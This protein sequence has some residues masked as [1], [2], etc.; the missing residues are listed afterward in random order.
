[1]WWRALQV[2]SQPF[3]LILMRTQAADS[4]PAEAEAEDE[5]PKKA[6]PAAT[7]KRGVCF[8]LFVSSRVVQGGEMRI[9]TPCCQ[10]T[11]D[12]CL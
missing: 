10:N 1:M 9:V 6:L 12:L 5:L 4:Q 7:K 11:K 3:D 2:L 8:V